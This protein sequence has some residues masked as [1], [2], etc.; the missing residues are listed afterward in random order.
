MNLVTGSS[1]SVLLLQHQSATVRL[2]RVDGPKTIFQVFGS[3]YS[4]FQGNWAFGYDSTE[5]TRLWDSIPL[6]TDVVVTHTPPL[7]HCD[8]KPNGA[9]VGCDALRQSLSRIRPQLAVCGHVHE[10]RGYERVQWR[11]AAAGADARA[12]EAD[13]VVRGI[14]TPSG[15][16]KQSLVDLTG[17]REPRLDNEGFSFS[18]HNPQQLKAGLL[19]PTSHL[20]SPAAITTDPTSQ[21]TSSDA[22]SSLIPGTRGIAPA[23]HSLRKETCIVNAAI[24]ATSWPHPGGKQFNAPIIVDLEL[25][26]W[27]N[28]T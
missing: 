14:L 15:S 1:P 3:P 23:L 4:Q 19:F 26:V 28:H 16:K 2:S 7:S 24:M 22:S 18:G 21:Q 9:S 10:G 11:S 8:Q 13:P 12:N 20:E 17:K 5:A 6:E 25:P 27:D